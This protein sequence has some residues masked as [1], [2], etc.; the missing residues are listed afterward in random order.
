MDFD[1]AGVVATGA[2]YVLLGLAPWYELR[3]TARLRGWDLGAVAVIAMLL[4]GYA[5][6]RV[7]WLRFRPQRPEVPLAPAAEPFAASVAAL[8]LMAYRVIDVPELGGVAYAR[9]TWLTL[10]AV[11][12]TA[13]ALLA[14]RAI[15][16]T[17]FRAPPP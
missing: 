10:A 3:D 9:T 11:A 14:T 6:A 5:A 8:A 15:A 17:G 1:D 13:Q 4:A 2:A 12:V 16:K 7:V